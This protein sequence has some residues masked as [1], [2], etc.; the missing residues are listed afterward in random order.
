M[1]CACVTEVA[2]TVAR[3]ALAE[4]LHPGRH[5]RTGAT[6]GVSARER[7]NVAVASIA[8]R[9]GQAAALTN[10]IKARTGIELPATPRM[11]IADHL[12]FA[13][14]A[15]GQWLAMADG[16]DGAAFADDLARDLAGLAAVTDQ[17]DGRTILRATGSHVRNMLAKGCMLDLHD[18]VFKVGDTAITP[19]ALLTA[20][21]TRHPDQGG[22]P[23]FELAVMRS[24]A[25]SFWHWIETSA[26]EFGLDVS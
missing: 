17:S 11:A 19:I 7:T 3:S 9:K 8:A 10:K 25:V 15:P 26:A 24:F 21:I 14:T 5:G 12:S 2:S 6:A 4:R 1:E 20:Q 23:V 13:W 22:L 18:S 16:E